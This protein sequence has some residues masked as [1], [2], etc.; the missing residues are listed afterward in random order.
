M[1]TPSE[2]KRAMREDPAFRRSFIRLILNK[3][4]FRDAEIELGLERGMVDKV[5]TQDEEFESEL[6]DMVTREFSRMQRV[7][8][9]CRLNLALRALADQIV[10]NVDDPDKVIKAASALIKAQIDFNKQDSKARDS[11]LDRIWEE[12][13]SKHEREHTETV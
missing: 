7:E 11:D 4:S 5:L 8:G 1:M 6:S 3:G 12:L 9:M 10:R 2:F 13:T